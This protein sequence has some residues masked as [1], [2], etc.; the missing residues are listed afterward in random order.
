MRRDGPRG[1]L[2]RRVLGL[3][4]GLAAC[5]LAGLCL[6]LALAPRAQQPAVR[7]VAAAADPLR[8]APFPLAVCR[9]R[10]RHVQVELRSELRL[11]A[12]LL[13]PGPLG[14]EA[15]R[16]AVTQQLR[17]AFA[18]T[19]HQA[20]APHFLT[21]AGPPHHIE[22]LAVQQVQY[23]HD[24]RLDWPVDP[25]VRPTMDYVRRAL[26]RG[27]LA[28]R[29]PALRIE[30]RAALIVAWCL[31]SASP[32]AEPGALELPVPRD[33][34]LL[35]WFITPAQRARLVYGTKSALTF[36]CAREDLADYDHPEFLWY[37]T[38]QRDS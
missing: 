14:A 22:P 3:G 29:D 23:G 2:Q 20:D 15:L 26:A 9:G 38:K 8:A 32:S 6:T 21:P 1:P 28:A 33:P 19:Q 37:E 36:P 12:A 16:A 27:V 34:Y 24:L 18:A 35:H 11:H 5:L 17:Y 31:S 7:A 30:Y 13:A 4:L 25:E 10:T